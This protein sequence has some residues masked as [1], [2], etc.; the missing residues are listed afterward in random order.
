MVC[1]QTGYHFYS[2]IA[3]A[4][5]YLT[6]QFFFHLVLTCPSS[7]LVLLLFMSPSPVLGTCSTLIHVFLICPPHVQVFLICPSHL[8]SFPVLGTC[9]PPVHVLLT[10]PSHLSFSSL[11]N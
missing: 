4:L 5:P 10:Y 7:V 9:P 6:K 2:Q 8:S 11:S 1:H 3:I